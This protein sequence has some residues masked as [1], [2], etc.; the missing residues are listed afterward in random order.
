MDQYCSENPILLWPEGT[1][2]DGSGGESFDPT[3]TPYLVE[4]NRPTAAVVVCPGGG[5]SGRADHEGEPV[6]LWINGLGI[7]SF[8]LDYRV[9]PSRHPAPLMDAQR[10]IRWVR[11]KAQE[12]H[13][14]AGR[15]GILGFSAG[16][17]LAATAA[18][19]FDGG[20]PVA[21]DPV[22]RQSSR[23]DAAVLCYPVITFVDECRHSGSMTNLLGP[24]PDDRLRRELSAELQVGS[25][26]PRMFLWHTGEDAGVPVRNSLLLA[27]ALAR[28]EVP[29]SLHTYP[30]GAHGLGL[31]TGTGY[32]ASWTVA[33]AGWLREIGFV[34]DTYQLPVDV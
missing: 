22:E 12:L 27:D 34:S 11:A 33:C 20:T 2:V 31:A 1:P 30:R 4:S 23:P 28:H 9:A 19:H 5:Y 7:S 29:F 13:V 32:T 26:T 8:V 24:D 10:A 21:E 15:V 25:M 17:H 14:D 3:I 6:A 18:T 16:G